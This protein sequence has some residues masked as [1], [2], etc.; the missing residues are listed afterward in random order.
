MKL[1]SILLLAFFGFSCS[2]DCER[3]ADYELKCFNKP[4]DDQ[5]AREL[6]EGL[7]KYAKLDGLE[8]GEKMLAE[9]T[10]RR[11]RCAGSA[12]TCEDYH[13]CRSQPREPAR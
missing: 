6:A 3:Y 4:A 7:C 10:L 13:R 11:V 9:E 1:F 2:N 5:Q 8:G 12:R